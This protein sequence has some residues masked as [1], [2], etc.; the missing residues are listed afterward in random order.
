[1]IVITKDHM[2]EGKTDV[3]FSVHEVGKERAGITMGVRK[4][5]MLLDVLENRFDEFCSTLVGYIEDNEPA[6]VVPLKTLEHNDVQYGLFADG[7]VKM[8]KQGKVRSCWSKVTGKMATLI[9]PE[10]FDDP[11]SITIP[12]SLPKTPKAT[13][14][15]EMEAMQA[16]MNDMQAMMAQLLAMQTAKV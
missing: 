10:T 8:F 4:A 3:L 16:R 12:I 6:P 9:T 11:E 1:M 15:S 5:K 14:S 7:V 13:K 2:L